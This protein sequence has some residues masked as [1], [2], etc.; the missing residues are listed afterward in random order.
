MLKHA[1]IYIGGSVENTPKVGRVYGSLVKYFKHVD[2]LTLSKYGHGVG[3]S[4]SYDAGSYYLKLL[5]FISANLFILFNLVKC[6]PAEVYAIN[7]IAGVIALFYT[8]VFR[9][10]YYYESLEIFTGSNNRLYTNKWFRPFFYWIERTV[11][12]RARY[13]IATDQ[14]RL[15]FLR[16]YYKIPADK[17]VYLYNTR[18]FSEV[19]PSKT[20]VEYAQLIVSYCG[21]LMPGRG[22]E[23]IIKAFA[24]FEAGG[25]LWLVGD[26]GSELYRT[27]LQSIVESCGITDRVVFWGKVSH[28]EILSYMQR[29]DITFALYERN[30][31]N[32]RL[33]SPN[34]F[35][36]AMASG[37]KLITGNCYLANF[38]R[39]NGALVYTIKNV[40]VRE[41]VAAFQACCAGVFASGATEKLSSKFDWQN[42][43]IKLLQFVLT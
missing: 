10:K 36:D 30:C 40:S 4:Y 21:I 19:V 33:C 8:V 16:R 31:V 35:F 34:K 25:T 24:S 11:A 1:V 7:P 23:E 37:V 28:S 13:F 14:F 20:Q 26:C 22:I 17:C 2:L 38:L 41:I 43:E 18:I 5:K 3:Y 32:N 9:K 12:H 15:C 29:S 39:N 42:E 6:R 27:K